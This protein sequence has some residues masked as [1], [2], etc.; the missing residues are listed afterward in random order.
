[1]AEMYTSRL[2]CHMLKM[3]PIILGIYLYFLR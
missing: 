1:M 2:F 3:M